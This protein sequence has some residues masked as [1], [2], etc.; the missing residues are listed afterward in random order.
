MDDYGFELFDY[1]ERPKKEHHSE[2]VYELIPWPSPKKQ[3]PGPGTPFTLLIYDLHT[4]SLDTAP[5]NRDG[6]LP[7]GPFRARMWTDPG[8]ETIRWTSTDEFGLRPSWS[9]K[10]EIKFYQKIEGFLYVEIVRFEA[11]P[12]TSNGESTIGIAKFP[13]PVQVDVEKTGYCKLMRIGDGGEGWVEA[14]NASVNMKWEF[15]FDAAE[16]YDFF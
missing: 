8:D 2:D 1:E 13:L 11:E 16:L 7:P 10:T 15:D 4:D 9:G 3:V 6:I 5:T 14:G 12:C